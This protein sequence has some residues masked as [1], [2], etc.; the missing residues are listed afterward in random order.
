MKTKKLLEQLATRLD[1]EAR[2][3]L[4]AEVIGCPVFTFGFEHSAHQLAAGWLLLKAVADRMEGYGRCGQRSTARP[5]FGPA[6]R[7]TN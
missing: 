7:Q 3:Q 5:F 1:Y 4:S 6:E 2:V